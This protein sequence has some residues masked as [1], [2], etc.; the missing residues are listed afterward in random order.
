MNSDEKRNMMIASI[1]DS[2]NKVD[3]LYRDYESNLEAR[4]ERMGDFLLSLEKPKHDQ[5]KTIKNELD[6]VHNLN[7]ENDFFEPEEEVRLIKNFISA[8][9]YKEE[10]KVSER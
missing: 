2:Y 3:L 4:K 1:I 7:K 10:K 8:I 6:K 5:I 9:G